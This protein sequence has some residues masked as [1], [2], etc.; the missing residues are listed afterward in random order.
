MSISKMVLADG[1]EIV[2][3]GGAAIGYMKAHY[4]SK[5][6]MVADWD[7]LTRENLK[8]VQVKT[9]DTVTANYTD[10]VLESETSALD[11]AG[12]VDTVWKVREQS[13]MERLQA[14]L[15]ETKGKLAETQGELERINT[16]LEG[17]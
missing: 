12:E 11:A 2:L 14:E 4:A 5:A 6:D 15:E 17:K 16:A 13:Q 8:T 3:A 7:K 1:T 9:D 10:L